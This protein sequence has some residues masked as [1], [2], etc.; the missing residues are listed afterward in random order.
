MGRGS[1]VGVCFQ[2]NPGVLGRSGCLGRLD[3]VRETSVGLEIGRKCPGHSLK[4]ICDIGRGSQSRPWNRMG[5][6]GQI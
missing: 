2:S 6:S 3:K 4:I 5:A 1:W